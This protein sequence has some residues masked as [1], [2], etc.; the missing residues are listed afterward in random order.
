MKML[1]KYWAS[2]VIFIEIFFR[3]MSNFFSNLE[4]AQINLSFFYF[5]SIY[6][7][8]VWLTVGNVGNDDYAD[9]Q[10][11]QSRAVSN[12]SLVFND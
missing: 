12:P 3:E 5:I 7:I 4:L 9:M 2:T 1:Q 10:L 8:L 6:I 11:T